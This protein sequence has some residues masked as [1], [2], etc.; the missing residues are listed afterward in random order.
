[1][2][3]SVERVVMKMGRSR[4]FC[5][6]SQEHGKTDKRHHVGC[7]VCCEEA[8]DGA[9]NG[10]RKAHHDNEGLCE[11]FKLRGKHHVDQNDG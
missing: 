1:M 6:K 11:A 10:K 2:P 4:I 8:E 9:D 7:L 5:D 3:R